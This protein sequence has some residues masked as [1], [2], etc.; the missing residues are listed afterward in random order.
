MVALLM[1]RYRVSPSPPGWEPLT[2]RLTN[3]HTEPYDFV[4]HLYNGQDFTHL[5]IVFT[6]AQFW[7]QQLLVLGHRCL[8]QDR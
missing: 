1:S 6:Q 2:D 5:A 4:H 8:R 7:A 3:R